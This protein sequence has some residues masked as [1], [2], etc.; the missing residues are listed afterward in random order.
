[1]FSDAPNVDGGALK[2]ARKAM[3]LTQDSLARALEVKPETISR[4][5]TGAAPVS[6]STQLA[7]LGLLRT[8]DDAPQRFERLVDDG[9]PLSKTG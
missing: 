8:S 4:W 1:L 5:E 9:A 2:F 3:G 7:V 6:R